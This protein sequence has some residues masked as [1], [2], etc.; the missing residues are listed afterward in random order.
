[1]FTK[2]N[3]IRQLEFYSILPSNTGFVT[4]FCEMCLFKW[5]F[6]WITNKNSPLFAP[7]S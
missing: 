6:S 5:K 2:L 1:M 4:G 3:N 7:L